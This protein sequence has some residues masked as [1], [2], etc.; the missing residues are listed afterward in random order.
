[1]VTPATST[2]IREFSSMIGNTPLMAIDLL[3]KGEPRVVYAKAENLNMTGSIKDR[4]A[5]HIL[6]RGYKRGDLKPED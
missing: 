5:Y 6:N 3:Y 4:M 1:M 2:R